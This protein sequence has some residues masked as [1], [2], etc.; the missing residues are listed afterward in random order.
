M[1]FCHSVILS[2]CQ[3][4]GDAAAPH[5]G[6]VQISSILQNIAKL[7]FS[8]KH[9][10]TVSGGPALPLSC[11]RAARADKSRLL[12]VGKLPICRRRVLHDKHFYPPG[13]QQA[14]QDAAGN[15][16]SL[17]QLCYPT[18]LC[19]SSAQ[20]RKA[21]QI[22]AKLGLASLPSSSQRRPPG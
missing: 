2:S 5:Q 3:P 20:L 16:L 10:L 14:G 1:S 8:Y 21:Q 22:S 19:L 7:L 6:I 18:K 12:E 4:G 15:C 11:G 17:T 9:R 13:K